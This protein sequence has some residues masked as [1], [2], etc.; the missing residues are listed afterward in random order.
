MVDFIQGSNESQTVR[1][2]INIMGELASKF[3]GGEKVEFIFPWFQPDSGTNQSNISCVN[4]LALPNQGQ[5]Y[6]ICTTDVW[7]TNREQ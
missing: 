5:A 2:Q 4:G 1:L 3:Y 6:H 7:I